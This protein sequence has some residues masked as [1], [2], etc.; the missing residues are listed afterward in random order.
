MENI[1]NQMVWVYIRE[2]KYGLV[3][4]FGQIMVSVVYDELGYF[5]EGRLVVC[6][7]GFWGFVNIDGMEVIFCCFC[8]V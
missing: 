5:S 3:D 6:C 1:D 4:I 7:N 2:L 8:E